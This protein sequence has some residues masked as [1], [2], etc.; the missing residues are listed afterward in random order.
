MCVA[1]SQT[2]PSVKAYQDGVLVAEKTS[3]PEDS[4]FI[5]LRTDPNKQLSMTPSR[6]FLGLD[7]S[8]GSFVGHELFR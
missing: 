8:A 7:V 1:V 3:S 6:V 2:E 4:L 5:Y